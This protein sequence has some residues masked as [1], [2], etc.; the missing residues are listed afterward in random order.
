MTLTTAYEIIGFIGG[1]MFPISTGFQT[2]KVI[3]TK[4]ARDI[5]YGW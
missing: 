1:C 4:S 2:I 3:R 5:S